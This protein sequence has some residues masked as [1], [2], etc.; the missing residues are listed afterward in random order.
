MFFKKYMTFD[1]FKISIFIANIKIGFHYFYLFRYYW[2]YFIIILSFFSYSL[3]EDK[4]AY[5][6]KRL[7]FNMDTINLLQKYLHIINSCASI[8]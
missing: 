8:L 5:F 6:S 3:G 4:C 1:G 7:P 2:K